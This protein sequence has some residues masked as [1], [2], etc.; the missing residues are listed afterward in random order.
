[1][2]EAAKMQEKLNQMQ[3]QQ[4][5]M[6]QM[7]R[8]A[9]GLGNAAEAIKQ[10][11]SGQAGEALEDIADQLGEMQQS[12]DELE[13]L[14]SSLGDLMQAKGQMQCKQCQGQ[15]CQSC[16]GMGQGFGNKPGQGLGEGQGKGDRPEAEDDTNTYDTQVRGDVKRGKA[17]I[18][19]K[20]GGPNRKG[21]SREAL[22]Q[23]VLGVLAEESDPM[24]NQSLPRTEREHAQQYFDRLR[25]GEETP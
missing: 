16:Q 23:A 9:Q 12:M 14:E 17:V 15:G 21:V 20:A 18:A 6:D 25:A 11:Q 10:G 22:Q 8:L 4:D 1:M 3:A 19:G 2:N 7:K 13:D 24:E 5:K